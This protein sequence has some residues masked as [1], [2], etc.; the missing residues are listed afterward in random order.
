M[1]GTSLAAREPS[2]VIKSLLLPLRGISGDGACHLHVFIHKTAVM[3]EE[4]SVLSQVA[5]PV[6]G[7]WALT[8]S[9][10]K[11]A[12]RG[13]GKTSCRRNHS[14]CSSPGKIQ[15]GLFC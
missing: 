15:N 12:T 5:C 14:K 13:S 3:A 4:K 1:S 11:E 9:R 7:E 8:I 10:K 2:A 6:K